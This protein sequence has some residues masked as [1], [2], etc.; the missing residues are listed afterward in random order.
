MGDTP[1]NVKT[2]RASTMLINIGLLNHYKYYNGQLN[3][4]CPQHRLGHYHAHWGVLRGAGGWV[5]LGRELV[6]YL[7]SKEVQLHPVLRESPK[8]IMRNRLLTDS[9]SHPTWTFTFSTGDN[10]VANDEWISKHGSSAISGDR[11]DQQQIDTYMFSKTTTLRNARL[12][13]KDG[14]ENKM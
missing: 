14:G 5:R 13:R 3:V 12:T 4:I 9:F 10:C 1:E 7:D 11:Q 8:S 2:T 6:L